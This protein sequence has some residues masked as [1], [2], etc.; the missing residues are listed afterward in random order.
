MFSESQTFGWTPNEGK[1]HMVPD[2][3]SASEVSR[4]LQLMLYLSLICY[5]NSIIYFIN[6]ENFFMLTGVLLQWTII[7][8][9]L[10]A[11]SRHLFEL[12]ALKESDRYLK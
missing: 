6:V 8:E 12:H 4:Y 10:G 1:L 5:I 9:V 2:Y 7:T 3:F 11:N